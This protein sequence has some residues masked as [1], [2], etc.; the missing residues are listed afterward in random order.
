MAVTR[1]V[2]FGPIVKFRVLEGDLEIMRA[3]AA[4]QGQTLS[5][6]LRDAV[7]EKALDDLG[8]STRAEAAKEIEPDAK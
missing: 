2:T 5:A 8:V 3:A 7:M 1:T 4:R 6:Y